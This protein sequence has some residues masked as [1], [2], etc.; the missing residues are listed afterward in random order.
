[1]T[2]INQVPSSMTPPLDAAFTND[3]IFG[4]VGP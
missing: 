3:S 4:M 1:M 2:V